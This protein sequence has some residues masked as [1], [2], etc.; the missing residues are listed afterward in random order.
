MKHLMESRALPPRLLTLVVTA[1]ACAAPVSTSTNGWTI[2]ADPEAQTLRIDREPLGTVLRDVRLCVRS[3]QGVRPAGSWTAKEAGGSLLINADGPRIAWR[4]TASADA[5]TIS[6]TSFESAITAE[7]PAPPSRV[8]A[9]LLDPEGTPV[10]W[11]GTNEVE[12]G[13]GGSETRNASFLPRHNPDVTYFALGQISAG[14][15]HSLF[16]RTTDTAIDFPEGAQLRRDRDLLAV[17]IPV[18][19]NARIRV[20]PKYYT[21][22]LGVPFYSPFDDTY[23]KT[24]PMVWSSWTSYYS[25]VR[26]Q[27]MVRNTDWI[28][29]H[30]KPYGFEYVELD[31]GYDRG[32][33]GEHDWI[34]N[35]NRAKFPHGPEWLTSYIRS[36]GLRA[37]IWLVPNAYAG[38]VATHP[39]WYVR[40]KSGKVILD[41]DTPTLDSSNPQVLEF[42]RHLFTTLD[43]WGFDYYKFDG[44]HAF[45]K[46][47]PAVDHS[48]LYDPAADPVD[49]Y[50]KRLQIIRETLGPHR[51]IEGCPAGTPLNG[52]GYFQSYFNGQDLYNNWEGMYPLFSSITANAFLNH[53]AV[54]VMPGEGL[55]LGPPTTVEETMK[56]RPPVVLEVTRSRE[57]PVTGFGTTLAEARTLVT[58]VSLT[59]VAYPLAS[60]MPELPEERVRLLKATLP[61]LPIMPVD[62]FSRGTDAHQWDTFKHTTPDTYIHNY[63]EILDL[64]VNAASGVYDVVALTNW[65]SEPVQREVDLAGKLGLDAGQSYVAFDYWNAK[66]LGTVKDRLTVEIAPHDTRVLL[67]HPLATH[68]QLVGISRHISGA[69]SVLDVAWD[70]A[71][72]TLRGKSQGVSGEPYTVYIHVPDGFQ[73]AQAPLQGRL[74]TLTFTGAQAPT[75][76][77]MRFTRTAA[78]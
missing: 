28:A 67:I 78:R 13:Y 17:T 52:I 45:P 49:V 48:K 23:F 73:P 59:G 55:E 58:W 4:F 64:K 11:V 5:L 22:V 30:L 7:A 44:E 37:G 27:D 20:I 35:W 33:K 6:S 47:V 29:A 2:V 38:A 69:W 21:K 57:E 15:L 77:S 39:D 46:Y 12:S 50:R 70:D 42:L 26:E 72:N 19:G 34:E 36:K 8:P 71:T 14:T 32:P 51:F 74:A 41:Y 53:I 63:P 76:W 61:T 18:T 1:A 43:D 66:L 9:R 10:T 25:D 56:N 16:D 40:D 68:P 75:D 3:D 65:R 54:Y 62:L 60:V 31:D 24:A